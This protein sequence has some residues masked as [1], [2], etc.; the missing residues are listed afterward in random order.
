MWQ[1]AK[2]V[3]VDHAYKGSMFTKFLSEAFIIEIGQIKELKLCL[4]I[5]FHSTIHM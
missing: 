1:F 4:G 5:K 2:P 3:K